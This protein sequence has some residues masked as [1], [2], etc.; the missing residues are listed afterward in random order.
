MGSRNVPQ[1]TTA[2]AELAKQV[3]KLWPHREHEAS[4]V[5]GLLCR[6]GLHRWRRLDLEK[7][8]PHRDI[9]Y[10]FWCSKVRIDGVPY[11]V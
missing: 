6:A 3:A 10:C 9:E 7:L 11:D 4:S 8:A 2:E 1:K 5:L